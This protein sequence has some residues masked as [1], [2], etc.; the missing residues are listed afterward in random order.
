[1]ITCELAGGL[2]N[3]LFQIFTTIA[4][5]IKHRQMFKFKYAD[6]LKIGVHRH[7]YWNNFFSKIKPF[8]F[9]PN[10]SI[11]T[12]TDSLIMVKE[13]GFHYNELPWSDIYAQTGV[14]LFGYFQSHKYFATFFNTICKMLDID[15]QKINTQIKYRNML[16]ETSNYDNVDNYEFEKYISIHFRLGDYKN[17]QHIYPILKKEY[18]EKALLYI[19]AE[20]QKKDWKILYFCEEKSNKEVEETI[21]YLK[22]RCSNCTFIKVPDAIPDWEQMLLMSTCMHNIIANST[23][24]WWGAYLNNNPNKTVCYP[25]EWFTSGVSNSTTIHTN[26]DLF[27]TTWMMIE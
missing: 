5:A 21:N 11:S 9:T 22:K 26:D 1:M 7:T 16:E 12:Q 23:F 15:T 20:T 2:G 14:K 6:I 25:N 13:S 8:T 27:P 4:Y 18:Y 10:Q 19:L 24:S 17:I 3:Q